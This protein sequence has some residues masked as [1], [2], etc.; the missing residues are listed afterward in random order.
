MTPARGPRCRRARANVAA[1]LKVGRAQGSGHTEALV[2]VGDA[3]R[4]DL[5][6]LSKAV[7]VAALEHVG[8][9]QR[10]RVVCE[11]AVALR[12]HHQRED[13]AVGADVD[14]R[15]GAVRA[16]RVLADLGRPTEIVRLVLQRVS[17]QA[18]PVLHLEPVPARAATVHA[19]PSPR[20]VGEARRRTRDNGKD[21]GSGS[22]RHRVDV[23][24]L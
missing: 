13:A 2:P 15:P 5:H 14:E 11:R 1:D 4:L 9:A 10:Q 19:E 12:G 24:L 17:Q 16:E 3:E 8:H 18:V 20:E 23:I 21:K 6:P 22:Q 7:G